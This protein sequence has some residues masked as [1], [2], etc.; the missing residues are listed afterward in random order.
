[1][2][3]NTKWIN[4]FIFEVYYHYHDQLGVFRLQ[5]NGMQTIPDKFKARLIPFIRP[6]RVPICFILT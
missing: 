4:S 6:M 2:N 3:K 5:Y 1:M